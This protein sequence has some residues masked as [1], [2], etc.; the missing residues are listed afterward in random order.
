MLPLAQYFRAAVA[1][2]RERALSAPAYAFVAISTERVLWVK[3]FRLA[4]LAPPAT[5]ECS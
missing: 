3:Q 1:K 2:I 5:V 4:L